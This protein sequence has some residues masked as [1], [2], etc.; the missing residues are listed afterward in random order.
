MGT[1]VG[2]NLRTPLYIGGVDVQNIRV[3]PSV[4]VEH[5]FTGCISLVSVVLSIFQFLLFTHIHISHMFASW[6]FIKAIFLFL[7]SFVRRNNMVLLQ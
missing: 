7:A 5:G 1:A 4:G 6:W 2:L 3:S